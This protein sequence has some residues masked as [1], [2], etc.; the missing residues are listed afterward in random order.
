MDA[1]ALREVERIVNAAAPSRRIVVAPGEPEG[2]YYVVDDDGVMTRV[3]AQ[4]PPLDHAADD[5]P[6]LTARAAKWNEDRPDSVAVWYDR[7]SVVAVAAVDGVPPNTCTVSLEPSAQLAKLAE[8][9]K[10]G[11]VLVSQKE[12]VL[13]L[14]TLLSG[15]WNQQP[16]LLDAV[17]RLRTQKAADVNSEVQR[18]RVSMGKTMLAEM[19]GVADIPERVTFE[20]P[21]FAGAAVRAIAEVRVVLDPD[22][23]SEQLMVVVLPDEI[24][25]AFAVGEE[26]AQQT[27]DGLLDGTGIPVYHGRP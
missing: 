20:V 11:R 9:R 2:V 15:C 5:L 1:A 13:L 10:A 6:T 4:L 17:R 24:D 8:W 21:V 18:G 26:T 3:T 16:T 19:S 22:P 12:F 14:R 7:G 25:R 23:E 27:L